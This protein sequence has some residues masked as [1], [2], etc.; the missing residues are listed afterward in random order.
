MDEFEF[1]TKVGMTL[2]DFVLKKLTRKYQTQQELENELS[3]ILQIMGVDVDVKGLATF[4]AK[5][6]YI[7][8]TDTNITSTNGF[9]LGSKK[10]GFDFFNSSI[11]DISGTGMKASGKNTGVRGRGNVSIRTTKKGMEFHV[12][13]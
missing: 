4:L 11:F 13:E 2:G 6:G 5:Q 10:G 1:M 8:I 9:E 12:G 3:N 7:T